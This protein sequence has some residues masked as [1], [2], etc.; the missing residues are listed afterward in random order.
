MIVTPLTFTEE[1]LLLLLGEEDGAS[2][3]V[4]SRARTD[5]ELGDV[6]AGAVIRIPME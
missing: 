5:I 3:P 1:I 4:N 2:L 6:I